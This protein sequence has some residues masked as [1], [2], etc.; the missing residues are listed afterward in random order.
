MIQNDLDH[1]EAYYAEKLWHLLPAVYRAEDSAIFGR[2][3]PLQELVNRL[4][5]QAAILRRSLDRQWEDQS[6][7]T[8]DDWVIAYIGDLLATN[9]VASL[10]ARGQRLDVAN[11]IYFRQRKG[12]VGILEE[13]AK[14]ITGWNAKVVEFF[15]R[16]SRQR[17]HLDPEIGC[18][19]DSQDEV[20]SRVL[21][22]AQGLVGKLTQTP[23]GGWADL[24]SVYGASQTHSAFD[25]FFYTADLRRGR[26]QVGWHNIPRLG[27]FLWR[28]YSFSAGEPIDTPQTQLAVNRGIGVTPVPDIHCPGQ[29]SLDPTGREI[30]LFVAATVE[31]GDSWI[32][33]AEWQLPVPITRPLLQAAM[34]DLYGKNSSL[35]IFDRSGHLLSDVTGDARYW[36]SHRDAVTFLIEPTIGRLIAGKKAPATA[37][38]VTYH[39]GFSARIGAGSYD[40]RSLKLSS[41]LPTGS[42]QPVIG[43]GNKLVAPLGTI[44]P[45][46]TITIQDSLTYNVVGNLSNIDRV[47]IRAANKTRPL[48]RLPVAAPQWSFTGNTGSSLVLEGLW[49][50]GGDV[51]LTGKFDRVYFRC[52]TLDPGNI[53]QDTLYGKAVDE[54]ELIRRHFPPSSPG[55]VPAYGKA[56]D[57]RELIP[58]HLWIE[59][60]IEELIID[61]CI[62]GPIQTRA[63]GFVSKITVND[64]IIQALGK[65]Q[66]LEFHSGITNLNR[67]TVMGQATVHQLEASECILDDV[68]VVENYQ[69]GCVRFTAWAMGSQL[70]RPYES[71]WIAPQSSLFTTRLFGQPGYGQLQLG[72]DALI[73]GGGAGATIRA[74]AQNGSEMGAF[75]QEKAAIK[76]RS[77]RIKY[78]EYL[79][80]GL[81]PVVVYVT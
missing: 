14:D 74:G 80:L 44:A 46:G 20:G 37:P 38:L 1:Y 9:L 81:V 63:Q 45:I 77:L 66:A 17:H 34:S 59:A 75:T 22:Q 32:S 51:V 41:P 76:E 47:M 5:A 56:V 36:E 4:G 73:L 26:G 65:D 29:Y 27:V 79:P 64:S 23:L 62:F 70:P 54:Q 58:G 6:I 69:Q 13:I 2:S 55:P 18:P 60:E 33:P 49:I 48:I 78:E 61:A 31:V 12:T 68:F 16:L 39:S 21:A 53:G 30:P 50:A 15:H 11:T 24:R 19:A 10:D 42:L 43:G 35:G 25:E 57:D 67:C 7:E 28:L 71:V 8:C 52:C 40:R 3:G 72:V